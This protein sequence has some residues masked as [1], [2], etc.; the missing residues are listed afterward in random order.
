MLTRDFKELSL[1]MLGFGC[2]RLPEKEGAI[3]EETLGK[4]VDYAVGHGIKYFD[5]AWPYHRGTSETAVGKALSKYPRESFYLADKFPGF[6]AGNFDRKEEIFEKQLSKCGVDYFDFYLLHN[7]NELNVDLYLSPEKGLLPYLLGQK[8]KGRIRHLGFSVHGDIPCLNRFLDAFGSHMEFAQ[9]QLN[10]LDYTFQNA[11]EKVA[12]LSERGIPVWVMEPLRGGKLAK[13]SD[14]RMSK[15]SA[16]RPGVSA[17]EWGF[18]FLQNIPPVTMILS[19]MSDMAQLTENIKIFETAAPLNKDEICALFDVADGIKREGTLPCTAC[20]YCEGKCRQELPISTVI[21]AYNEYLLSGN[22]FR[23]RA[24]INT[25]PKFQRPTAC[26]GCRCC[27]KV[28]PQ[29]I[30]I[31]DVMAELEEKLK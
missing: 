1:P 3:D 9:I 23:T 2:M 11:E 10:Y 13:L 18:R 24:K 6:D 29:N 27:E 22:L 26:V 4:M 16:F 8:E 14:E 25:L 12:I 28:C 5:T 15:L 7:V 17:P 21:A 19:G 30:K 20:R 31:A